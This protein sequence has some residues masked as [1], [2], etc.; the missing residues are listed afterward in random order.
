MELKYRIAK[1]TSNLG[2]VVD[3]DDAGIT[4]IVGPN[5]VG[6]SKLLREIRR[7]LVAVDDDQQV[8][9]KSVE[10]SEPLINQLGV[11]KFSAF[12]ARTWTPDSDPDFIAWLEDHSGAYGP[13]YQGVVKYTPKGGG[14][15]VTSTTFFHGIST[16]RLS[17]EVA[18]FFLNDSS[19]GM[20]SLS[21]SFH[22]MDGGGENDATFM[23]II[24]RSHDRAEAEIS[25]VFHEVFG[26]PLVYDQATGFY[27]LRLGAVDKS[28]MVDG[29]FTEAYTEAMRRLPKLA[30]QGNGMQSFVGPVAA[31]LLGGAQVLLLDEPETYLHPPQARAL[32]RIIG[33]ES[34]TRDRQV[35]VVTHDRDLVV[36]LLESKAPLRFVRIA[37]EGAGNR[38]SQVR[39]DDVE[40]IWNS[41][42]LR[43][44]NILSGL[45]YRKVIACESDAD[46]RFYGAVLDELLESSEIHRSANETL[47]IPSVGKS[48]IESRVRA[49]AKLHV[50]VSVIAD[51]DL[52]LDEPQR[53]KGILGALGESW[54][55]E[56]STDFN[57]IKQDI[58]DN[59]I[60]DTA[61][62]SGISVLS[63]GRASAAAMRFLERLEARG[64]HIVRTGEM[65]S[66]DKTISQQKEAWVDRALENGLH[67]RAG[68][69]REMVKRA[70]TVRR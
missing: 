67:R 12:H 26:E 59:N 25:S 13:D 28:L 38:L 60:R 45:F 21:G 14:S 20:G 19:V 50:S 49:L 52:L 8:V 43:Y 18:P 42:V 17:P 4:C 58:I 54:D 11:E 7:F 37:R 32:G 16:E 47:F 15:S 65:E 6:K 44:S 69:H 56:D 39:T 9:L 62:K 2:D 1:L 66:F 29:R 31:L 64:V 57:L 33:R 46:C 55:A 5:N 10:V 40:W 63:P 27:G 70:A 35:I 23:A 41:A 36:G 61:K 3:L 22:S 30:I 34:G 48:G 24:H 53:I 68:E 51:F